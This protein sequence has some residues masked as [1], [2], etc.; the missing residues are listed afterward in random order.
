MQFDDKFLAWVGGACLVGI[1]VGVL[2]I[3]NFGHNDRLGRDD[4]TRPPMVEQAANPP[5]AA[6]KPPEFGVRTVESV[7]S[8][9]QVVLEG[10]GPVRLLGVD[11]AAAPAGKP[12]NTA[13]SQ[14]LLKQIAVGKKVL[15]T[16]DPGTVDTEFKDEQG[17][18]LVYLMLDDGV[19]V[20]TELLARGGAV[21]DLSRPYS[22]KDEFVRAERDARWNNRGI[23]QG[24]TVASVGPNDATGGPS[25]KKVPE[26][27]M[28]Q[29]T[30]GKND[31]LVT[32]DGRFHRPSC[33]LS[34]GGI[35][36]SGE[37]ARAKHYLACPNCFVSP[38][39]KV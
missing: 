31:V 23:W 25:T 26:V 39:V 12:A 18:P 8:G 29:P 10:L 34:K 22:R 32:S 16:G 15:V 7:T 3:R 9:D 14:S 19:I 11:T 30:P 1:G 4:A 21:A 27:T 20:N 17:H 5:K 6:P 37:D 28:P 35:V 2:L 13:L 24:S 38:K 36:M 33:K